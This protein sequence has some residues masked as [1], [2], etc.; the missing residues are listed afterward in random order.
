MNL[1]IYP[2]EDIILRGAVAKVITRPT[3]GNLTP[4]GSADGFNSRVSFGNPF[5]NPFRA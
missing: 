2:T 3:L 5:L 1:G 4:G